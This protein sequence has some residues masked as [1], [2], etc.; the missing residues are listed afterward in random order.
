MTFH[1]FGEIE[2][3][4]FCVAEVVRRR[5][6]SGLF[7]SPGEAPKQARWVSVPGLRTAPVRTCIGPA[8]ATSGLISRSGR[9]NTSTD[10]HL[11][12]FNPHPP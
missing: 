6:T 4:R 1:D 3:A 9:R 11:N 8:N 5:E 7:T 2:F 10:A 12:M